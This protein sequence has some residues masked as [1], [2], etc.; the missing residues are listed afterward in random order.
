V[1]APQS[2]LPVVDSPAT[3]AAFV[4]GLCQPAAYAALH[5]VTGP[6][7]RIETHV[8]W[9]F[10]TGEFAYKVKKPLRLS[11][12]DY[13]TAAR[14]AQFCH[15]ELRLNQRHAPG[16][17][18][19]VV[20]ITGSP[21]SPRLERMGSDEI[22]KH[23]FEH[24]LRMVQFDER[25]E[26]G[27]LLQADDVTIESCLEFG[28]RIARMQQQAA[29]VEPESSFGVPEAVHR[30][31]LAN[32]DEL[33]RV[34]RDTGSTTAL[35][36]GQLRALQSQVQC[37]FDT[38]RARLVA[39]REQGRVREG[40][41]DLHCGNVVRWQGALVAFD[42]IEFDPALR[43]IDVANDIAFLTMDLAARGRD[44]L[45]GAVLQGWL[46]ASGD[47]DGLALLPY[48]E[49]YR[50]L[51]R[52][53]VAALRARQQDVAA[54]ATS[55]AEAR[56]YL[57]WAAARTARPAP[58]LVL[59]S[60]LSGSG[61]TWLAQRIAARLGA[62]IVR[63]DVERKRLA[64]LQPLQASRSA[65]DA[66]LY[67]LDFNA[68]TYARLNDC[69]ASG[70]LGGENIIVDAANLRRAERGRFLELARQR[71]ARAAIVHCSAPID[72]LRERVTARAAAANDAS[73]ATV[74]LLDRQPSYWE[75]FGADERSLLVQVD[76]TD[77][78]A[79]E[80]VVQRL[81]TTHQ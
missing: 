76:T 74:A 32:F 53:K 29:Q 25:H 28:D 58:T 80:R 30:T 3:Q 56:R 21:S 36:A 70:L 23:T 81:A 18:L 73:E 54:S 67:S 19:E 44:D 48:F 43:W 26:L 41:G 62:L 52:A 31:T 59:M 64:G 33:G 47:F 77:T 7:R 13:S 4:A 2:P 39:R 68:R 78:D 55:L 24:A 35:D 12:L 69:A 42:G 66:G 45:R 75:D 17:Y 20:A 46:A 71:G 11:F 57:D 34:S 63:S 37:Q 14:R 8:S 1:N 40:H 38:V 51:V 6:V 27:H 22:A 61:K 10:L 65:P 5:P 50:A 49:S 15:E 16:L 60:G 72:V 9:V 79:I